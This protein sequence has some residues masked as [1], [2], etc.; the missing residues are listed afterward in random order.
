M[1]EAQA[2]SY[3]LEQTPFGE[4]KP[5]V[6]DVADYLRSRLRS[7]TAQDVQG[8]MLSLF[9]NAEAAGTLTTLLSELLAMKNHCA[10]QAESHRLK[11]RTIFNDIG[12]SIFAQLSL[13]PMKSITLDGLNQLSIV[14]SDGSTT[15][16]TGSE[17]ERTLI[18]SAIL[19][20]LRE[21]YTPE[22]PVLMLDGMLDNLNDEP[23]EELVNFLNAYA[24][25]KDI[26]VIATRL[27]DGRPTPA[28]V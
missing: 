14:W 1:T 3:T 17:G 15:G 11:A 7:W 21:A 8:G 10:E 24:S 20:A 16:L 2:P 28:I 26:A 27:D 5:S 23:R 4:G 13:S 22:I 18:A 9:N 25:E 12:A 19:I 6:G